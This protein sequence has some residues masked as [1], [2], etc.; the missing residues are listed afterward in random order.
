MYLFRSVYNAAVWYHNHLQ[1]MIPIVVLTEAQE[2]SQAVPTLHLLVTNLYTT[3]TRS[4]LTCMQT[5]PFS[6]VALQK[7]R[8]KEE[9]GDVCM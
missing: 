8:A 5:Y 2:V 4:F 1:Q 3:S 6:F 9:I 7:D